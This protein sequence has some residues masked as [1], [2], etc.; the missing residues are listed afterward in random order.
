MLSGL[1]QHICKPQ[2]YKHK[3]VNAVRSVVTQ[4]KFT[5]VHALTPAAFGVPSISTDAH[6]MSLSIP[7]NTQQ[8]QLLFSLMSV[9]CA[10]VHT[11]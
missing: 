1:L 6:P 7:V 4:L 5:N 3:F 10:A 11:S 2:N 9:R 8:G